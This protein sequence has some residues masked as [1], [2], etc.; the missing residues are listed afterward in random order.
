VTPRVRSGAQWHAIFGDG[1]NLAETR[2]AV[3]SDPR[4]FRRYEL[5]LRP[6]SGGA[7]VPVAITFWALRSGSGQTGP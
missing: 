7:D 4:A 1:V 5:T 3:Q 2:A 6:A